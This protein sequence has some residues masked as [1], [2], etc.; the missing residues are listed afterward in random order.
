MAPRQLY[1]PRQQLPRLRSWV[2]VRT[3]AEPFE[4]V[5]EVRSLLRTLDPTV[6]MTNIRTLEA[7]VSE[8]IA[9]ERFRATLAGALGAMALLLAGIGLYGLVAHRVSEHRSEIGIRLALGEPARRVRGRLLLSALRLTA[10]GVIGGVGLSA[11]SGRWIE[12]L[13]LDELRPHDPLTLTAVSIVLVAVTLAAAWIPARR[14]TR[15]DPIAALRS[16]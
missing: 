4:Y 5:P 6:P 12:T 10:V 14:A 16:E 7:H 15:I 9:P 2:L 11:L 1:L 13:V 8:E 3:Q